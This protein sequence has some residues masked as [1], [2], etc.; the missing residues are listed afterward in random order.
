[1]RHSNSNWV[2]K[3]YAPHLYEK[4]RLVSML[5]AS[6]CKGLRTRHWHGLYAYTQHFAASRLAAIGESTPGTNST[7]TRVTSR[8]KGQKSD[9]G[10]ASTGEHRPPR[11]VRVI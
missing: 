2:T 1:M 5:K 3:T 11:K 4:R 6:L 7:D 9:A 10:D 8:S